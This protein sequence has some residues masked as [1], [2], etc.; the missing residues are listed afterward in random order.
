MKDNAE[1]RT[2]QIMEIMNNNNLNVVTESQ[3]DF[4]AAEAGIPMWAFSSRLEQTV[5][6]DGTGEPSTE[7][8][9]EISGWALPPEA[10]H[11]DLLLACDD[12]NAA[13]VNAFMFMRSRDSY[14]ESEPMIIIT[15]TGCTGPGLDLLLDV[16]PV[17]RASLPLHEATVCLVCDVISNGD[18]VMRFVKK[19]WKCEKS[20]NGVWLAITQK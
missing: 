19:G 13:L 17:M 6:N 8:V 20:E 12:E 1:L 3:L 9:A 14:S 16:F 11:D 15:E 10:D 2:D 18:K 7:I 4:D 5:L